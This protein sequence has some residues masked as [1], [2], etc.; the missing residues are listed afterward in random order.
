MNTG[1]FSSES[2]SLFQ[3]K[4][5]QEGGETDI[6][7]SGG[8]NFLVS[9]LNTGWSI[10]NPIAEDIGKI[11]GEY[12]DNYDY[13]RCQRPNGTFYGT[14]GKCRLGSE[15]GPRQGSKV[16]RE[17]YSW[18]S[19]VK[20]ANDPRS[21]SLTLHPENQ[22][23]VMK[24][25]DGEKAMFT[26]EQGNRITAIREGKY[27]VMKTQKSKEEFVASRD[28]ISGSKEVK[29]RSIPDQQL[30]NMDSK[31][32]AK[33]RESYQKVLSGTGPRLSEEQ[34]KF[35]KSELARIKDFDDLLKLNKA[36][37]EAN[38]E[39]SKKR[40]LL[41][42]RIKELQEKMDDA[43]TIRDQQRISSAIS[44]ANRRLQS[45]ELKNRYELSP[46]ERSKALS[47]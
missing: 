13:T 19:I 10:Q 36:I 22:D 5:I 21:Q 7:Y 9:L 26:D 6:S 44:D 32:L 24:L 31:S 35:L 39:R 33:V 47:T 23:Q 46:E 4:V 41:K 25:K 1:H 3:E 40:D 37:R 14:G 15:V 28:S 16:T 17:T 45:D 29:R 8:D 38:E 18:G 43:V 20:V 34:T 2:L 12:I 30:A 42:F 11:R 27:I